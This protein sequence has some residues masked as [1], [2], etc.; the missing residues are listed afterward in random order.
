MARLKKPHCREEKGKRQK[1]NNAL[2]GG[3]K[4]Y[5]K[6]FR[7]RESRGELMRDI[8]DAV[9]PVRGVDKPPALLKDRKHVQ[10]PLFLNVERKKTCRPSDCMCRS[11][12]ENGGKE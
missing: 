5:L 1:S 12:G 2:F 6:T 3:G 9:S 10:M 11:D 7:E 4:G 8:Q